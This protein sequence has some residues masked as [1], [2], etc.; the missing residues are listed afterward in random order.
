[1]IKTPEVKHRRPNRANFF[2]SIA[3][4]TGKAN[5]EANDAALLRGG[6]FYSENVT[7]YEN[8]IKKEYIR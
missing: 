4:C 7:S 1:M 8:N 3:Q 2:L 5:A 6:A